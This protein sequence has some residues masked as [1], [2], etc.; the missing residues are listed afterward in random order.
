MAE[1]DDP[2]PK[3]EVQPAPKPAGDSPGDARAAAAYARMQQVME[4]IAQVDFQ[5][6]WL[7]MSLGANLSDEQRREL[8][9]RDA[10][11]V[12][13]AARELRKFVVRLLAVRTGE[14]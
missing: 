8:I 12:E 14:G 1:F 11:D 13:T 5:L 9:R 4:M 3:R 2:V 7:A 6:H 10:Q